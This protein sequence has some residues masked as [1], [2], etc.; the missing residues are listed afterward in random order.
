M[1]AGT[2][3]LNPFYPLQIH[4]MPCVRPALCC[5]RLQVL[6]QPEI[7]SLLAAVASTVLGRG[8]TQQGSQ[9]LPASMHRAPMFSMH[10][11]PLGCQRSA[12]CP[13]C[14]GAAPQPMVGDPKFHNSAGTAQAA[15]QSMAQGTA[16]GTAQAAAQQ[17]L[18]TP[19]GLPRALMG[20]LA[21][22][23]CRLLHQLVS[24]P[25]FDSILLDSHCITGGAASGQQPTSRQHSPAQAL[26]PSGIPVP[27]RSPIHAP[28]FSAPM[29][30]MRS[31]PSFSAATHAPMHGFLVQ[32]M[33][34]R[35]LAS[36]LSL[37][38]MAVF[39]QVRCGGSCVYISSGHK[40]CLFAGSKVQRNASAL[41]I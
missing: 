5:M 41:L 26:L 9:Q 18:A 22:S 37:R 25:S 16:Q 32:L 38:A 12:S 40:L 15:A 13:P 14:P 24:Q 27:L 29:G 30:L 21:L 39:E 35:P 28:L 4:R 11:A 10:P 8:G 33:W 3:S 34:E 23:F 31:R 19:S 36:P 6:L 2:L 1:P 20:S 17:G 7:A